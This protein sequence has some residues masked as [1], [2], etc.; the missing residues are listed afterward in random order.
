MIVVLQLLKSLQNRYKCTKWKVYNSY[1]FPQSNV[2][3]V[4]KHLQNKIEEF[5]S[6]SKNSWIF[7]YEFIKEAKING[8]QGGQGRNDI[9]FRFAQAMTAFWWVISKWLAKFFPWLVT[10]HMA[11]VQSLRSNLEVKGQI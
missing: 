10:C 1:I 8:K 9:Y 2:I 5:S 7:S 11:V 3:K 4:N 6:M